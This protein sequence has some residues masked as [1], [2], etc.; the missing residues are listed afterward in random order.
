MWSAGAVAFSFISPIVALYSVLGAVLGR[1]GALGWWAFL[2]VFVFQFLIVLTFG[3]LASRWP[4]EGSVYQ[5]VRRL[6]PQSIGWMTG[7]LYS[8]TLI[9]STAAVAYG[10]AK[11]L[12]TAVGIEH[13]PTWME[14]L[15]A[16]LLVVSASVMNCH[17]RRLLNYLF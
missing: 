2:I 4:L 14:L 11:F 16:A 9:I 6:A 17:G 13:Q 10:A 8:W 5:W 7:W 1:S 15:V 12:L 3:E